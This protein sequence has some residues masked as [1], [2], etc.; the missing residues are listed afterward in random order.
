MHG[1]AIVQ[2]HAV[3][4]YMPIHAL[5]TLIPIQNIYMYA[6][7]LLLRAQISPALLPSVIVRSVVAVAGHKEDNFRRVCLETLR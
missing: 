3:L 1:A 6:R 4:K 5:G 2:S 7:T